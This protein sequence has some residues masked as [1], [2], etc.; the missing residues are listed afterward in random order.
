MMTLPEGMAL[1]KATAH[2][3]LRIGSGWMDGWRNF[4]FFLRWLFL[5]SVLFYFFASRLFLFGYRFGLFGQGRWS[6]HSG[7]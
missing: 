7:V 2:V 6:H 1:G 5:I 3:R 4:F